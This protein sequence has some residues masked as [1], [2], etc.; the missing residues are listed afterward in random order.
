MLIVMLYRARLRV[1]CTD[2]SFHLST[3]VQGLQNKDT[4]NANVEA[5]SGQV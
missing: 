4:A 1:I 3:V 5:N 2:D